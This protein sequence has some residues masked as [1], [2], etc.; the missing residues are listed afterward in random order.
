MERSSVASISEVRGVSGSPDSLRPESVDSNSSSDPD[1]TP[2]QHGHAPPNDIVA[3]ISVGVTDAV[4]VSETDPEVSSLG[5]HG[6]E[7]LTL[8]AY[9][10]DPV[11][12]TDVDSVVIGSDP[13]ISRRPVE[14]DDEEDLI[15]DLK[16][17]TEVEHI[18]NLANGGVP[19]MGD[20]Q[21]GVDHTPGPAV[22]DLEVESSIVATPLQWTFPPV[23]ED[24][25]LMESD[26]DPSQLEEIFS[27]DR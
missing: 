1:V 15:H 4:G 9:G 13:E 3:E 11:T 26:V 19:V 14:A 7:V 23:L 2:I 24:F 25:D 17:A 6:S 12:F 18:L 21:N 10:S 20:E 5:D 27:D 8:G 16:L 22:D